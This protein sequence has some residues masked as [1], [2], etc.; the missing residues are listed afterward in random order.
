MT[1]NTGLTDT[2]LQI[3]KWAFAI[4]VPSFFAGWFTRGLWDWLM[5]LSGKGR[6]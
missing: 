2:S 1:V 4:A 6:S 3:L 5:F